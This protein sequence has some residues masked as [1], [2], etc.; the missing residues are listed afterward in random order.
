M[1]R[2]EH[3]AFKFGGD[4][5]RLDARM[6]MGASHEG[7]VLRVRELEIGDELT[8]AAQVTSI[9]LAQQPRTNAKL[10]FRNSAGHADTSAALSRDRSASANALAATRT[11]VT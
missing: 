8:F 7:D 1:L 11:D 5:D 4:C 3:E 10:G 2:R 9:F 6:G